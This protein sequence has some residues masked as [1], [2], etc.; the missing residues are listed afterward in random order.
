[1]ITKFVLYKENMSVQEAIKRIAHAVRRPTKDIGFAGNKDKRGITVQECSIRGVTADQLAGVVSL[2]AGVRIGQARPSINA[3]GL[4]D[5]S[6]NWF[7][8]VLRNVGS[9]AEDVER[10]LNGL[11]E[12][13]FLNYYGM[14]RFGIGTVPTHRI[15]VLVLRR[16][17]R[18]V[19]E[20]LLDPELENQENIR[21]AKM[22]YRDTHDAGAALKVLPK[23]AQAEW[24][25]LSAISKLSDDDHLKGAH[26][27]FMMVDRRQRMMYVHAYQS[28]LWNEMASA[29]WEN[30][31]VEL[32]AGDCVRDGEEILEVNNDN[33]GR[34]SIFDV[35]LPLPGNKASP[36]TAALMEKDGVTVEMFHRLASEYGASGDW[37]NVIERAHDLEW[38]FV[39]HNGM[40]DP[41]LD[42]DLDRLDGTTNIGNHVRDGAILSLIVSFSLGK[43]QYATMCLR[44]LLKRSTEAMTDSAMSQKTKENQP[45]WQTICDVA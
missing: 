7:E 19:V 14:Q 11:R 29:R 39:R 15:G 27:L 5:N 37:R 10:R 9:R 22:I 41:L 44:E 42:S 20:V 6:G 34:Y 26:D 23:S 12:T 16:E 28:Y 43:G 31:G 33:I 18:R 13:G 4:G 38:K 24:A 32:R 35:V 25:I 17:W 21:E 40:D 30:G 8:I 3:V 2:G 36:G 1:L 45:W